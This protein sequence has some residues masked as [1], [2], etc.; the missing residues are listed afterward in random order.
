M[1]PTHEAVALRAGDLMRGGYHCS[2]AITIAVGEYLLGELD[3][4]VR[5]ISNS[6]SGG[7]GNTHQETCGVLS[8]CMVIIGLLHGRTDASQDDSRCIEVAARCR[9]QFYA[10]FGA[11]R[12]DDLR[13]NGYGTNSATPCSLL[14]ERA[15]RVW[16]PILDSSKENP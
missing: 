5:R 3:D 2:E 4:R 14:A 11:T 12:C 6:F 1:M 15:V 7:M 16:L 10:T 8:G 9:D 13:N